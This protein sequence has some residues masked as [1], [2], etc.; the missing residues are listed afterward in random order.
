MYVG[1][2]LF[3]MFIPYFALQLHKNKL[4]ALPNSFGDLTALT[5]LDLSHNALTTLPSNIFA[6]PE[7]TTLNVS[8]NKLTDL[9]FNAPF[10]GGGSRAN[11]GGSSFFTPTITR[12]TVPLPRLHTLNASYNN[13]A[14]SGIHLVVPASLVK[15]DLS[16]NPLGLSDPNCKALIQQ[17]GG[18]KHLK[19]AHFENS[20]IGDEAFPPDAFPSGS[21]FPAIRILDFGETRV[22]MEAVKAAL[23][24]MKQQLSFDVTAQ[25]PPGG[26]V[27]VIIG[28]KVVR[29]A[30][31]LEIE[32]RAKSRAGKSVDIQ[33]E[34]NSNGGSIPN[35]PKTEVE[36]EAW[37]VEAE[38]GLLTEGGKRRARAAAAA[39]TAEA[40]HSTKKLGIGAPPNAPVDR[41]PSPTTGP[42]LTSP[43]YY[44]Q[45]TQTLTLPPST[46]PAKAP[47]HG[48]AFSLAASSSANLVAPT[49]LAVPAP[50]LP[51]SVIMNQP[52]AKN[53]R[54]L[55]LIN[56]RMDR[57]FVLP[58]LPD[59]NGE[60]FLPNLEVL[61]LE[62]CGLADV[63]TVCRTALASG[64][65]T[66]PRS[67][68]PILPLLAKLF[69]NLRTLNLSYNAITNASLTMDTLSSLILSSPGKKGLKHLRLRGNGFS[70]LTGF[71][72]LAESFKGNREVP[73]WALDELDLRDNEI[74]KLP[75][76]L[77][78]LPLEVFLVDGNVYVTL[79]NSTP[80][81]R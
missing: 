42:P 22:T 55:I 68:E 31:E 34:L 9:P 29:E 50:T 4:E 77:G 80:C 11:Q 19:E 20:E 39:A 15:L 70:D 78:L 73:A 13:I 49:H 59:G 37:E 41:T 46:A 47:G 24:G 45:T 16:V 48:R 61:N 69:P 52:F 38:Q 18:L 62:G 60:D 25:D 44:I 40:K 35:F 75:P 53:L 56:R 66:P 33:S 36:K 64:T 14:A 27:Q 7:L 5:T 6:L 67:T 63:V 51:L 12:A 21:A 8:H 57:S 3:L 79:I 23:S 72:H 32:R 2:L 43:Q 81:P 71:Q 1:F 28:K 65:T 17:L 58:F 76:E 30:W 26:V 74:G 10:A 54:E